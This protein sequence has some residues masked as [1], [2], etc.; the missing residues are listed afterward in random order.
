[1]SAP[2][3]S[4]RWANPVGQTSLSEREDNTFHRKVRS[5]VEHTAARTKT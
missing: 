5:R 2:D 4:S 3:S 1:M